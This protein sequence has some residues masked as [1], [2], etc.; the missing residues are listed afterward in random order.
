MP[1]DKAAAVE[2]RY[3]LMIVGGGSAGCMLASRLSEDPSRSVLLIE[4]GP[5]YPPD[6]YP[7]DLVDGNVGPPLPDVQRSYHAGF[8]DELTSRFSLAG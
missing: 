3:D 8:A 6:G 4:A 5:T 2:E 1:N 7:A